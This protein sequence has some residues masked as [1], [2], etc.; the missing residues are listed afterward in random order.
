[1]VADTLARTVTRLVAAGA[2]PD[3]DLLRRF[4]AA[5][6]EAAFAQLVRR[7]GP[8]VFGVCRRT[9]GHQQDSEDAFQATFLVLARK[10][11]TVRPDGVSRWLYGVAVRVANKARTRRD[12]RVPVSADLNEVAARPTPTPADW[13]PLLDAALARMSDRDRGPIVL[14]DLLGRSRAEAAAE[15]GVGEGTLSS[16]LARARDKLRVRLARLG[17]V[18]GV[19][20][21]AALTPEPVPAA[22]IESTRAA[23]SAAARHLAEGVIRSMALAKLTKLAALG[24][25]TLGLAT[26]IAIV[27]TA[28]AGPTPAAKDDPKGPPP[29]EVDA[30][31]PARSDAERL[32][33][34][35]V[36]ES[37]KGNGEDRHAPGWVGETMT[38]DRDKVRFA[39]FVGRDQEYR[40]DPGWDQKR[41]D[42]ELTR[43]VDG[44]PTQRWHLPAIYR[45]EGE[46]LHL[47]VGFTHRDERPESFERTD[48]GT[49]FVHVLLRKKADAKDPAADER[50]A[51]EGTWVMVA[52]EQNGERKAL[53]GTR[54]VFRGERFM[55]TPAVP[56]SPTEG[57]FTLDPTQMPRHIDL[58][59]TGGDGPAGAVIRGVYARDRDL[60]TLR[61]GGPGENRPKTLIEAS[62]PPTIY[63]VREGA[64]PKVLD[65]LLPKAVPA[66]VRE[67]QKQ[68]VAALELQLQGQFERVKI[69]K[70]PL[71]TLL[72]AN[73]ELAE[74]ELEL[75]TTKEAKVAAVEKE[76]R[77]LREIAE[78]LEQLQAAGLQNKQ[79]VAQAKAAK[80][81][82]E[83]ELEKLKAEK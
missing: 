82:A 17:V 11:H 40:L 66:K 23:G 19:L 47:V 75:A 28:G 74:A 29:R 38:F 26:G 67:L 45:F 49:P 50:A 76:L 69:G 10:A 57:T 70:D 48:R 83:I 13:L 35:W 7:H 3:A 39:G 60:L 53:S 71:S 80:L 30:R 78:Q 32:R 63:F 44:A 77:A 72:M 61:V 5:R 31:K 21:V 16:R 58:T 64:D 2:G 68:R 20:A 51:L 15:L 65:G 43:E 1:M 14:C 33:G 79:G 12:R 34:T 62:G 27:P 36:V 18:P 6:D 56:R 81:K 42:F 52:G 8:M 54:L 37:A 46:K 24:V 22:L 41:I 55:T 73:H 25:C 59:T 4:V 9:L